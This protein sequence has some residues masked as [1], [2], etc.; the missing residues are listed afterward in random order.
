M[1][2]NALSRFA[3]TIIR[4]ANDNKNNNIEQAARKN[5]AKLDAQISEIRRRSNE[6]LRNAFVKIKS[7]TVKRIAVTENEYRVGLL[8]RRAQIC[9]EV[10]EAV[11]AKL[12]EFT[13]SADYADWFRHSLSEAFAQINADDTVCIAAER[14][15]TLA[16]AFEA[17]LTIETASEN[18]I[19]GFKLK[20]ESLNLSC[21]CTLLSK[22]NEQKEYFYT[23]SGLIIDG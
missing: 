13:A 5:K 4:Q 9:D 23:A 10:F 11:S 16:E 20:S 1:P 14:D 2:N 3:E 8:K 22:L 17:R 12:T 6:E 21:D 19:G 7:D 18:I 15:K